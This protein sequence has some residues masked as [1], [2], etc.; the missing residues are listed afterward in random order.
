M[1]SY[2]LSIARSLVLATATIA[3]LAASVSAEP[4]SSQQQVSRS[5]PTGQELVPIPSGDE[6]GTQPR[7]QLAVLLDT[8]NSM[9][10]LINQ[11]RVQLW[12]LVTELS[13]VKKDN[14]SPQFEVALYQYGNDGLSAETGHVQRVLAFTTNLD[15]MSEKLFQLKT[16]GGSEFCG[17]AIQHAT[18]NLEWS[19]RPDDLRMIVI[20]GNEPF[21]QGTVDYR[22]AIPAAAGKKI[23]LNTIH[24]GTRDVGEQTMWADGA[25]LGNGKFA[26]I[27]SNTTPVHID[28][29]YDKEINDVGVK[30]NDTYIPF[31][32]NGEEGVHRQRKADADMRG[33]A[34]AAEAARNTAKSTVY[35]QSQNAS[36]DLVDALNT[37]QVELKDVKEESLPENMRKMTQAERTAYVDGKIKDRQ[38][39]VMKL[40]ELTNKRELF[41]F[42]AQSKAAASGNE[43]TFGDVLLAAIREQA[44]SAGFV[45]EKQSK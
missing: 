27:D 36:W 7:I 29:P 26:N 3:G 14:K 21:T 39:Q 11:A 24:C 8:S 37:K 17:H 42:E 31:G 45:A 13:K 6:K 19:S 38:A 22:T 9:D 12:N 5:Q 33:V 20:A 40:A 34:P 28:T 2:R 23:V 25:K 10:G 43:S 15:E 16:N 44:A 32:A 4:V 30:I 18:L 1:I 35:Y 41:I